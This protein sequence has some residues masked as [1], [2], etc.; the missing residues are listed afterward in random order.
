MAR[1]KELNI[2]EKNKIIQKLA[3]GMSTL[4]ISKEIGR[5]HRTIKKIAELGIQPR[6]KR[7]QSEFRKLTT[8]D[9]SRIKRQ[10]VKTPN[11]SSKSIFDA[12]GIENVPRTTRCKVLK[13]FATVKNRVTGQFLSK[14]HKEARLNWAKKYIKTNFAKVIF[15][16]ESRV[17]LD[18]PDG[19]TRGWVYNGRQS[20]YRIRRQQ[21]GGGVMIWAGIIGNEVIGPFKVEEGVKLNSVN[22]CAFLAQNFKPWLL[23]QNEDRKEKLIFMQ[24]NAPSHASRYSKT[25]LGDEGFINDSLMDLPANSPDLNPIE[26]YWSILK[27][28]IYRDG[29]QYTSKT[30]L[31]E[32][33]QTAAGRVKPEV[34]ENLTKSVDNRLIKV[35]QTKGGRVN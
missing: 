1:K 4:E 13:K 7:N 29:K 11:V 12:C 23:A 2:E 26:H 30:E 15:T 27:A 10:V 14:K 5:D 17:T 28:A 35:L 21:G 9:L 33:I 25:W 31:W 20:L 22:Y 32:A 16:D 19:W 34:V 6:K 24:D 3:Q 18:G 8:R